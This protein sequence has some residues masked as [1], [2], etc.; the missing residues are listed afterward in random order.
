MDTLLPLAISQPTDALATATM[1][2]AQDTDARRSPSHIRLRRS[3]TAIGDGWT[4]PCLTGTARCVS[5]V[6][7]IQSGRA[8]LATLGVVLFVAGRTAQ[9]LNRFEEAVQLT[10]ARQLP[11]LFH[12]RGTVFLTLSR[13][14][15][16]LADLS[17]AVR[18]PPQAGRQLWEGRALNSRCMVLLALGDVEAAE[19]DAARA[20]E[21]LTGLGQDFEAAQACTTAPS[22]PTNAATSRARSTCSTR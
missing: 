1:V 12:R 4:R 10:P 8:T 16:A 19:A 5:R 11:R 18:L 20:E 22:P 21:L 14:T 13:Y 3:C 9:A 7:S 15:E 6:G 2:I 17:R